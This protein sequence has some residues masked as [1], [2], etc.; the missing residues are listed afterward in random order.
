MVVTTYISPRQIIK[1]ECSGGRSV[2][3]ML[4]ALSVWHRS[5][6]PSDT[7]LHYR[8]KGRKE[9]KTENVKS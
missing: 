8:A 5:S 9:V 3:S 2:S 1:P 7:R 6:C 4:T